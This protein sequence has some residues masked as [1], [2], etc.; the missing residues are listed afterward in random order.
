MYRKS[1]IITACILCFAS[2]CIETNEPVPFGDDEYAEACTDLTWC[3]I[4]CDK[5]EECVACVREQEMVGLVPVAAFDTIECR[6]HN[7]DFECNE[8]D[9]ATC[10]RCLESKCAT[11]WDACNGFG[12]RDY[13]SEGRQLLPE[14]RDTLECIDA[15]SID[16]YVCKYS[17]Y[18]ESNPDARRDVHLFLTYLWGDCSAACQG[19]EAAECTSCL[20][21]QISSE[22][23]QC[24]A[25]EGA[26]G[27]DPFGLSRLH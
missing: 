4:S 15:C 20:E 10:E 25:P 24:L 21:T 17:C 2:G 1:R 12:W 3:I 26:L 22:L 14:C 8:A 27:L 19:G 6:S 11:S 9:V 5:P 13:E 7:C 18:N 23:P 16:D